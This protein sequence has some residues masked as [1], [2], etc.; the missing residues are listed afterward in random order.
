MIWPQQNRAAVL[1]SVLVGVCDYTSCELHLV[2][3]KKLTYSKCLLVSLACSFVITY[4]RTYVS[5]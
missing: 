2:G 5:S 1:E 4:V 3:I